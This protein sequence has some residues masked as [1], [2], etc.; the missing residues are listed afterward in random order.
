M[1]PAAEAIDKGII[2]NHDHWVWKRARSQ[3]D[4]RVQR[5]F[6]AWRRQLRKTST[7]PPTQCRF[8]R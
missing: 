8:A 6:A 1:T 3:W 2:V 5:I 7:L 4:A